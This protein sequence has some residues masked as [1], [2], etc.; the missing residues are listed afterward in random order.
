MKVRKTS[1]KAYNKIKEEGLLSK[2]RFAVYEH[3]F[4]FGPLTASQIAEEKQFRVK[5]SVCARLTELRTLG[6]VE[7]VQEVICPISKQTVILWDVTDR[8]PKDI[9]KVAKVKCE[10]CQGKGHFVLHETLTMNF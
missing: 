4:R 3:L 10:Y 5:G 8:L 6:V 7:E 9:A 2:T 1:A